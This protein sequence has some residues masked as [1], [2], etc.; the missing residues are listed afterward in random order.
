[1]KIRERTRECDNKRTEA[2]GENRGRRET[3]KV[4]YLSLENIK[5]HGALENNERK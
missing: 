4:K 1:M 5:R 2:E 3:T